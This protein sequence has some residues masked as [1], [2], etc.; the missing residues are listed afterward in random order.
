MVESGFE[1]SIRS[2]LTSFFVLELFY[3]HFASSHDTADFGIESNDI[4]GAVPDAVCEVVKNQDVE[5]WADCGSS[6]LECPCC[7]VCCPGDSCI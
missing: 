1:F 6:F 5:M 2:Y 3:L 7:S 4:V